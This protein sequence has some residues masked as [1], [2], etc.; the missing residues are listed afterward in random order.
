MKV[1]ALLENSAHNLALKTRHGLSI[2]IE[3]AGRKLLFDAGPDRAYIEN[4][5]TLGIDLG[6]L[7]AA[8]FSHGHYDHIGGLRFLDEVNSNAPIY[9]A[10]SALL[11]HWSRRIVTL[12]SIGAAPQ[13]RRQYENRLRLVDGAD[14][15]IF[16]GVRLLALPPSSHTD[17]RFFKGEKGALLPDDFD[18]EIALVFQSA[19]GL[20]LFTG[21]SHHGIADIA[22][23]VLERFPGQP[24]HTL[25]GGFH[26]MGFSLFKRLADSESNIRA[27]GE[28][29]LTL[30]INKIHTCH[31][32]GQKAFAI[33]KSVLKDKL[34]TFST[35]RILELPD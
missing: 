7:D 10:E 9:M 3:S 35:G 34:E 18:H 27:L 26:L 5:R 19:Q 17:R 31:C 14:L 15:E 29:L 21:C 16:P 13:T 23:T 32:T 2:H 20:I 1:I 24:I 33:L 30:P 22:Q 4:A 25:I 12:H 8:V 28:K 6:E 11:P